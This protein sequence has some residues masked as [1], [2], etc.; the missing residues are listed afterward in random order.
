MKSASVIRIGD[1]NRD[2]KVK[3]ACLDVDPLK[4]KE[5]LE[6]LKMEL[7][8]KSKVNLLPKGSEDGVLVAKVINL[9]S[10]KD[11]ANSMKELGL[12]KLYC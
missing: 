9:N 5:A 6:W 8:R 12:A 7:P 1:N 4:E 10:E 2:Y 3:I 11:L